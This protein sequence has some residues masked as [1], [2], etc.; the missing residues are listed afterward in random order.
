MSYEYNPSSLGNPLLRRSASSTK[1]SQPKTES[2]CSSSCTKLNFRHDSEEEREAQLQGMLPGVA[3]QD[4]PAHFVHQLQLDQR[5]PPLP[6]SRLMQEVPPNVV[7]SPAQVLV[8]APPP[9]PSSPPTSGRS[10]PEPET[11]PVLLPHPQPNTP[12]PNVTIEYHQLPHHLPS[13]TSRTSSL[14][15]ALHLPVAQQTPHYTLSLLP[16]HPPSP[17]DWLDT[18]DTIS[19]RTKQTPVGDLLKVMRNP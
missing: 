15:P 17:F 8:C 11:L 1:L 6:L 19:Y 4:I 13:F 16:S 5:G 14:P 12:T 10:S 2:S 3:P 18:T 9:R 7:I